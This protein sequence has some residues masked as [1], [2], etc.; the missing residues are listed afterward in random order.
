MFLECAKCF[1]L[2]VSGKALYKINDL[3]CY[4]FLL[5][6]DFFSF[7]LFCSLLLEFCPYGKLIHLASV[8]AQKS[9]VSFFR[10]FFLF[11]RISYSFLH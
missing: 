4:T 11:I 7:V 10:F 5:S 2:N 6:L 9:C 8:F 3:H 1:E